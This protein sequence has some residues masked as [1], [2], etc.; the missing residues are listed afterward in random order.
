MRG[1]EE[2]EDGQDAEERRTIKR[3][4]EGDDPGIDGEPVRKKIDLTLLPMYR[5]HDADNLHPDLALTL[6]H[7]ENYLRDIPTAKHF[8]LTH[9]D[10]PE[11]PNGI[12][13]D[14]LASNYVNL[15]RVFSGHYSLDGDPGDIKRIGD[16]EVIS[17][18]SKPDKH[19]RDKGDW[20]G[21]WDT[22]SEAVAFAYPHREPE[23][24]SYGKY[25]NGL[26]SSLPTAPSRVINYDCAV[27]TRLARGNRYLLTE[28]AKF[29]DL[30]TLHFIAPGLGGSTSR[31]T[32]KTPRSGGRSNDICRRFNE[33]KC[34]ADPCRYRHRCFSCGGDH[35]LSTC[36]TPSG[37]GGARGQ[38]K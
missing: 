15:D 11:V 10:C 22:Y 33:G 14:V 2:A 27:R 21:A 35:G 13:N 17:G 4:R 20:G 6:Q 12:W 1:V 23:L 29:N 5:T 9:P 31:S 3:G 36:N 38:R 34:T 28:V 24:R 37:S 32:S 18:G 19:I 25:I 16:F 30:Y 26:F 7:K 8:I